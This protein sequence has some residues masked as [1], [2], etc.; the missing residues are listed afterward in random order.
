MAFLKDQ[1][2]QSFPKNDSSMGFAKDNEGVLAG[3]AQ[4]PYEDEEINS[5]D[6]EMNLHE[7]PLEDIQEKQLIDF[8]ASLNEDRR[9]CPR[10]KP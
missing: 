3:E 7:E 8:W 6:I 10:N 1:F 9:I 2:N 5:D 4:G